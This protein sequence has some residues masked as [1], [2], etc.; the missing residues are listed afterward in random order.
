VIRIDLDVHDANV[1]STSHIAE[2]SGVCRVYLYDDD[3]C[4]VYS[5][6]IQ[7]Q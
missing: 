3:E 6:L 2:N 7:S 5:V 4:R 1:V